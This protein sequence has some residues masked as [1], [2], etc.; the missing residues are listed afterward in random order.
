MGVS[1]SHASETGQECPGLERAPPTAAPGIAGFAALGE[2]TCALS[3][4]WER[5]G[6]SDE[7]KRGLLL[8][9]ESTYVLPLARG[10]YTWWSRCSPWSP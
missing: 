7:P 2:N 4:G 1:G 10:I 9:L 8:R 3:G 6:Q 5:D